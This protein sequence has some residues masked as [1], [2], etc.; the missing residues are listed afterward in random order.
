MKTSLTDDV[1]TYFDYHEKNYLISAKIKFHNVIKIRIVCTSNL[2][3]WTG[4]FST[5]FIHI[6]TFQYLEYNI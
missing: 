2:N 3:R 1:F 5:E 6:L 4:Q